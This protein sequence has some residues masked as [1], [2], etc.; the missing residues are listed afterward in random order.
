MSRGYPSIIEKGRLWLLGKKRNPTGIIRNFHFGNFPPTAKASLKIAAFQ[1]LNIL[2]QML[3]QMKSGAIISLP[4]R[5]IG[6]ATP[7]MAAEAGV[8]TA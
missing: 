5:A 7:V 1:R 8:R 2:E 4:D 3:L 6:I